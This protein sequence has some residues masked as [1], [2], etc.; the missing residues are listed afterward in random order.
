MRII[1]ENVA[2]FFRRV[3]AP[4][5]LAYLVLSF[6][7]SLREKLKKPP[8]EC[9][10]YFDV[11]YGDLRTAS[12]IVIG[13]EHTRYF[14]SISCMQALAQFLFNS[15]RM[16]VYHE[17]TEPC[18]KAIVCANAL[19]CQT[20]ENKT[21][22]DAYQELL[23]RQ[24]Y[25]AYQ[26]LVYQFIQNFF[27]SDR[28]VYHLLNN[29]LTKNTSLRQYFFV[30][31]YHPFH[32]TVLHKLQDTVLKVLMTHYEQN[33][34]ASA[35]SKKLTSSHSFFMQALLMSFENIRQNT[36]YDACKKISN[37]ELMIGCHHAFEQ[38]AKKKPRDE[39]LLRAVRF[40]KPSPRFL[41]AGSAHTDAA[42]PALKKSKA[43]NVAVL[44]MKNK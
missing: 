18:N 10:N 4:I 41:I 38:D 1:P 29:T 7:V 24:Y 13:E 27:G 15:D 43:A 35:V 30:D 36:P 20:W 9:S 39:A 19:S 21:A 14:L 34:E 11:V 22:E 17:R 37:H 16:H 25:T 32:P 40:G 33:Y 12:A 5:F 31:R 28:D 44:K 3:A 42:I 6:I 23:T 8:E 2:W 26:S